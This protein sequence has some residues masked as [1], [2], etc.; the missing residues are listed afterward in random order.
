[1]KNRARPK[2]RLQDKARNRVR[3]PDS[4]MD[5][6]IDDLIEF[7][8]FREK[9]LPAIRKDV[10]SG[11]SAAELRT[12]YSSMVQA[13]QIT[14][15]LVAGGSAAK[16]IIDRTEGKPTEKREVK[17]TF[18]SMSDEELDALLLSEEE[19]LEDMEGRFQ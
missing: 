10:A 3:S 2:K 19:D 4:F 7:E 16:D 8:D 17:H 9:I 12:K 6:L 13:R 14:E 18:D 15:A 11:M 5:N 1:M